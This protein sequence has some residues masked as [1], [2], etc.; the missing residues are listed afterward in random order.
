MIIPEEMVES[1]IE[2]FD[3]KVEFVIIPAGMTLHYGDA[4][5]SE[6][7]L[8]KKEIVSMCTEI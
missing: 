8:K 4:V 3:E 2:L 5:L 1:C 7:L 6:D